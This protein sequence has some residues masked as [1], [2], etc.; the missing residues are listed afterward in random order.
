MTA[1]GRPTVREREDLTRGSIARKLMVLAAPMALGNLAQ[2]ALSLI[3]AV[4]VGRL[5]PHPLAGVGLATTLL[6][7]IWTLLPAIGMAAMAIGSRSAGAREEETLGT[8]TAQA[9]WL[10]LI[11]WVGLATLGLLGGHYMI[12]LIGGEADA[13]TLA[14]GT[15][16]TRIIFPGSLLTIVYFITASMLR[17]SGDAVT[18]MVSNSIGCLVNLVLDPI[19][20]FGL[21]PAPALGVAGAAIATVLANC[22]NVAYILR[23]C[24]SGRLRL[25]LRVRHFRPRPDVVRRIVRLAMPNS[26]QYGLETVTMLLM[27]R[28]VASH[29][30]LTIAA[31]TIGIRLDLVVM[32]PG[33]AISQA[34]A[35]F[36]GQNLGA[37]EFDRAARGGWTA[38]RLLAAVQCSA[39]LLYILLGPRLVAVFAGDPVEHA[40]LIALGASY[41]HTVPWSY[42]FLALG[43]TMASGL[44][45]AGDPIPP[46]W[47]V[48][49]ARYCAQLPLA[50]FLPRLLAAHTSVPPYMGLWL[51][52]VCGH[53]LHGTLNA[54]RFRQGRWRERVV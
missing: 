5:G 50:W 12:N 33:W 54:A 10:G 45:G 21:G 27:M 44:T 35:S 30:D 1:G 18:P 24:T 29:G 16:Y 34:G 8:V 36:I 37:R 3:D 47:N 32:L 53:V 7:V 49:F 4:F 14:A 39:G 11:L 15:T 9:L 26:V 13:D 51:A 38:F 25:R 22:V 43:M 19:L 20:I 48:F 31:F 28:I 52:I 23:R 2:T 42:L 6:Y 41:V 46:M 40:R 17:G